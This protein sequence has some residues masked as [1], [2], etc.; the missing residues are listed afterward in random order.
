M[1][2]AIRDTIGRLD[3]D[4]T[5]RLPTIERVRTAMLVLI[6]AER[7][8]CCGHEADARAKCFS[9]AMMLLAEYYQGEIKP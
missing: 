1:T 3:I 7:K 2:T 8:A 4:L 9:D 6:W 5:N